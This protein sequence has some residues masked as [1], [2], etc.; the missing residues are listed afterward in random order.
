MNEDSTMPQIG[1]EARGADFLDYVAGKLQSLRY[2]S[3][4]ITVFEGRVVQ[5]ETTEKRRFDARGDKK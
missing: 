3:V 2:G 1:N 5:V 4:E